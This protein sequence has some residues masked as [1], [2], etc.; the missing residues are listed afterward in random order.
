MNNALPYLALFLN[1]YHFLTEIF[2]PCN[3]KA[4]SVHGRGKSTYNP[5]EKKKK[6]HSRHLPRSVYIVRL[7]GCVNDD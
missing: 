6:N 5:E 1:I 7:Q 2:P 3:Y 4:P